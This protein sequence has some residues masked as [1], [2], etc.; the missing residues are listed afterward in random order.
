MADSAAKRE[1]DSDEP[2]DLSL[3]VKRPK[4][5]NENGRGLGAKD[6]E[7]KNILSGFSTSKV[8]SDSAREKNIFVHGKVR[9][10]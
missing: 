5:D 10:L 7:P 6:S 2:D 4:S 1:T 8:L 3:K 9:L